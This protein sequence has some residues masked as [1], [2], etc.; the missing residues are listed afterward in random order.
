MVSA[1]DLAAS[2]GKVGAAAKTAG[3]DMESLSADTTT[4]VSAT[5]VSGEEAG[6]AIKSIISRLYR[7]GPEGEED[8]GKAEE[9]LAKLNIAVRDGQGNFR[10][11]ND[12]INDLNV[13]WSSLTNIQ[14][15]NISQVIAGTYH[16]SK[17]QAL[18]DNMDLT[19][20]A[21]NETLNSNN[22]ASQENAK[23]LDSIE[24]R[25]NIFK[26]TLDEVK[27]SFLEASTVKNVITGLTSVLN[28]LKPILPA[29]VLMGT[30]LTTIFIL[31]ALSVTQFA[32]NISQA[33]MSMLTLAKNIFTVD[34]AMAALRATFTTFSGIAFVITAAITAITYFIGKQEE[35]RQKQ[36]A[37]RQEISTLAD[38][39]KET[40]KAV[41]E[42]NV[43]LDEQRKILDTPEN[44]R[45]ADEKQRLHDIEVNLAQSIPEATTA[46]DEQ[47]NALATNIDLTQKLNDMKQEEAAANAHKILGSLDPEEELKKVKAQIN[48]LSS[49]S[50]LKIKLA[51]DTSINFS[52]I[53]LN[54]SYN[55]IG[56]GK[57]INALQNIYSSE[58]VSPE[59]KEAIAKSKSLEDITRAL[60]KAQGEL[61]DQVVKGKQGLNDYNK[62]AGFV[63]ATLGESQVIIK[64]SILNE[65]TNKTKENTQSKK[66]NAMTISELIQSLK[67]ANNALSTNVN[68]MFDSSSKSGTLNEDLKSLN[69]TIYDLSKGQTLTSD[70]ISD[71]IVKYPEL[72]GAVKLTTNGYV[73]EQSALEK[74]RQIKIDE[75][76]TSL[77]TQANNTKSAIEESLK[78]VQIIGLEIEAIKSKSDAEIQ[79]Q[80][81]SLTPQIKGSVYDSGSNPVFQS[82]LASTKS[83]EDALKQ[84]VLDYGSLMDRINQ[85]QNLIS[86]PSYGVSSYYTDQA[87]AAEDSA[88]KAE[89]AAKD[90]VQAEK[91]AVDAI[92]KLRKQ[93]VDAYKKQLEDQ[94]TAELKNIEDVYNAQKRAIEAKKQLLDESVE[95]DNYNQNLSKER[96]KQQNLQNQI[97]KLSLDTSGNNQAVL[98]DLKGQLE[99]QNLT[100]SNMVRDRN[101]TLQENELDKQS[102]Q[103]ED[104]YKAQQDEIENRY[105][106][107]E[108]EM[109]LYA[110]ANEY[111]MQNSFDNILNLVKQYAPDFQNAGQDLMSGMRS[112]IEQGISAMKGDVKSFLSAGRY[113]DNYVQGYSSTSYGSNT[114]ASSSNASSNQRTLSLGSRGEDVKA[115][116][117]FLNLTV[118]GVFGS[119]TKAA[120]IKFQKEHN[121]SADGVVGK[122]TH[123]ALGFDTGG[124]LIDSGLIYAHRKERILNESQT[125]AFD[126]LVYNK[127]PLLNNIINKLTPNFN[128]SS[129]GIP[130]NNN[131]SLDMNFNISVQGGNISD[132]ESSSKDI[133]NKVIGEI[134]KIFYRQG[135]KY[136][137]I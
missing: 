47:N 39:M 108:N 48:A 89:Q 7:I 87:K 67:E 5:G 134:N 12:I 79:A 70:A 13:Q 31:K 137:L 107:A 105:K 50:D 43:L 83:Q 86:S 120:V 33:A 26:A 59:T 91:N 119:A 99:E 64:D 29:L 21:Y 53:G 16:Y 14:K 23:Y 135:I 125:N 27:A 46:Y 52:T 96:K 58:Y 15:S 98:N 88:K 131:N 45:S 78:R 56:M 75:M 127:M 116:Q 100:I 136:K 51:K 6:T 126:N 130:T 49:I 133:A 123:Q 62:A 69:S 110:K 77:Q 109:T 54:A 81:I 114:S 71:L 60:T 95:A 73:I 40:E 111:I 57:N 97:A 115:L 63:N 128:P 90:R 38:T 34:G 28:V 8:Q 93:V 2:V 19:Q 76:K 132:Y 82:Y 66:E 129:V 35:A 20:K 55:Q 22:S 1:E 94:K 42:T 92:S 104:A 30:L 41:N 65:N 44:Q 18:M 17:F 4:L 80:K 11:F 9:A 124:L 106:Q 101:K 103:L 118:D 112:E 36:Q 24:G 61:E 117:K 102:T 10:S 68:N 25:M 84:Q 121:I 3:M 122:S 74:L 113:G 37:L 85:M 72:A 32:R